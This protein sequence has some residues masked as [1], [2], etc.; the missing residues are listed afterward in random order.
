M[1]VIETITGTFFYFQKG[2]YH[3][4]HFSTSLSQTGK[5]LIY[6]TFRKATDGCGGVT[7]KITDL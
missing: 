2:L 1:K 5:A 4:D 6:Y 3:M 7:S